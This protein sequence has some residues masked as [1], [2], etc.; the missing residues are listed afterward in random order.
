MR[1]N[2]M[3]GLSTFETLMNESSFKETIR[4]FLI[5]YLIHDLNAIYE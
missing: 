2:L 1:T 3:Y 4:D 5:S